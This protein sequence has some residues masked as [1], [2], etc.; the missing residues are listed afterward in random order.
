MCRLYTNATTIWEINN[1]DTSPTNN[2]ANYFYINITTQ[3]DVLWNV[4]CNNS[5]SN[6]DT[7]GQ[8]NFT[9]AVD[10]T[11][12]LATIEYPLNQTYS[13]SIIYMNITNTERHPDTCWYSIDNLTT[14]NTVSC[15]LLSITGLSSKTGNNIWSYCINDSVSLVNCTN[16][17]FAVNISSYCSV[18]ANTTIRNQNAICTVFEVFNNAI[19]SFEDSNLTA[20]KILV[21]S[22][23]TLAGKNSRIGIKR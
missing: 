11:T 13:E 19:A 6:I 5:L 4:E 15:S 16:V 22:G 1:T 20:E 12:P 7:S 10:T 3:N 9:F 17:S 21:E 18:E 23:S 14:N 2:T 8:G